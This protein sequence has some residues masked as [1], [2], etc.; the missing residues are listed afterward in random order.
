MSW[1]SPE[2]IN[3]IIEGHSV[4]IGEILQ[5]SHYDGI[6]KTDIAKWLEDKPEVQ[7]WVDR[8]IDGIFVRQLP[9]DQMGF[10]K[11]YELMVDLEERD[12][13]HWELKNG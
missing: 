8:S 12:F 13:I 7:Y 4:I 3:R 5:A 2:L 1:K 6:L 10:D 11:G 9:A